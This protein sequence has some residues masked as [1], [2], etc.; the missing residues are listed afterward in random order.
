MRR[1]YE[2][3]LVN[4]KFSTVA[5]SWGLKSKDS[6]QQGP[7]EFLSQCGL[8]LMEKVIGLFPYWLTW[9]NID[10]IPYTS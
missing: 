10:G 6:V 9:C 3:N 1:K 5:W 2:G 4:D 7:A 8:S